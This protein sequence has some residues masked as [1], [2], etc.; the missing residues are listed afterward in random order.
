VPQIPLREWLE[1]NFPDFD[2]GYGY[3]SQCAALFPDAPVAQEDNLIALTSATSRY[4]GTDDIGRQPSYVAEDPRINEEL[5]RLQVAYVAAD[6]ALGTLI[7]QMADYITLDKTGQF[8]Y[9][10]VLIEVQRGEVLMEAD[11]NAKRPAKRADGSMYLQAESDNAYAL[12]FRAHDDG[13]LMVQLTSALY[14][15]MM[16][17]V[18]FAPSQQRPPIAS[19]G[20]NIPTVP[21]DGRATASE[22][23]VSLHPPHPHIKKLQVR[24]PECCIDNRLAQG[25]AAQLTAVHCAL[26]ATKVAAHTRAPQC[27]PLDVQPC[28]HRRARAHKGHLQDAIDAKK[29]AD[30]EAPAKLAPVKREGSTSGAKPRQ[31]VNVSDDEDDAP[32]QD[33]EE[34]NTPNSKGGRGAAAQRTPTLMYAISRTPTDAELTAH[35]KTLQ[36]QAR[37]AAA[38]KGAPTTERRHGLF[39]RKERGTNKVQR[40]AEG[41]LVR[42]PPYGAA[43]D[44]TQPDRL[45]PSLP[46]RRRSV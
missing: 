34:F 20:D 4:I 27:A 24:R 14:K 25:R 18:A 40:S 28:L 42:R 7:R 30:H 17:E 43:R 26:C 2:I 9:R 21:V 19:S 5:Q 36:A 31:V 12:L 37:A 15:K 22:K 6:L 10:R 16:V 46:C 1:R 3:P 32:K 33:T 23:R 13:W 39:S 29:K 45:G 38:A 11:R 44:V 41:Y 35:M 8:P